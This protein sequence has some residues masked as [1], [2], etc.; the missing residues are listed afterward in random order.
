[1][2]IVTGPPRSG[3]SFVC[4]ILQGLG[5][6]FR[7]DLGLIEPDRWNPRGY[8]ESKPV[9]ELNHRLMFGGL[10]RPSDWLETT[11]RKNPYHDLRK[12][13]TLC[14]LPLTANAFT[15]R[16]RAAR[17]SREIAEMARVFEG[18]V[19]KDPRFCITMSAWT[20]TG[21][22]D[23]VLVCWRMPETTA[24]SLSRQTG[25]PRW[26]TRRIWLDS[27]SRF[28]SSTRPPKLYLVNTENLMK[29]DAFFDE[30]ERLFAFA[31]VAYSERAATDLWNRCFDSGLRHCAARSVLSSREA[32]VLKD[33]HALRR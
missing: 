7:A 12:L 25:Y 4:Q 28:V 13:M 20:A 8:F 17:M 18:A 22:V 9:I 10:G 26:M 29:P 27:L 6:E 11:W 1:M 19:A 3:T 15:F 24:A 33:L 21:M 30:M 23:R 32:R 2:K 14:A 5:E 16:R 31:G